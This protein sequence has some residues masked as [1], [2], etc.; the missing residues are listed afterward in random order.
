MISDSSNKEYMCI[1]NGI[2]E[3]FK[4]NKLNTDTIYEIIDEKLYPLEIKNILIS[5]LYTQSPGIK[6]ILYNSNAD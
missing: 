4:N 1:E 3:D 6:G 5:D 2:D